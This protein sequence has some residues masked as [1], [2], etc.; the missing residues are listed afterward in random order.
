MAKESNLE[1]RCR[2]LVEKQ[3]GKLLK[4]LSPG[5]KGVPDRILILRGWIVFVEFKAPGGRD[6]PLQAWWLK[7]LRSR[8]HYVWRIED[9]DQFKH[10]MET[11]Q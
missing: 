4:W 2:L 7:W 3:R 6:Q 5:A 9:Y 1:K 10:Y 11:L 8:G